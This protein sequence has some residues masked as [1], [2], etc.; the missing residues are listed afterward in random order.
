M[1]IKVEQT[2]QNNFEIKINDELKYFSSMHKISGISNYRKG[3]A[4]LTNIDGSICYTLLPSKDFSVFSGKTF[5]H[6]AFIFI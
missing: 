5:Q 6:L 4:T 2:E 1:I 3:E